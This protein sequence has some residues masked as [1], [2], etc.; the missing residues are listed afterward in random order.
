MIQPSALP[1]RRNTVLPAIVATTFATVI[2]LVKGITCNQAFAVTL[3]L[4]VLTVWQRNRM[5][6]LMAA[7]FFFLVKTLFVRIAFAIDFGLTGH[8]GFDLLGVTPAMLL[9]VMTVWQLYLDIAA[10]KGVFRDR[11]RI[12]LGIFSLI[13]ALSILNPANPLLNGLAGFERVILPNIMILFLSASIV[14]T[15]RDVERITKSLLVLGVASCLYAVGQY[16]LGAY[17]WEIDWLREVALKDGPQGLTIGLRGVELRLFSVFYGYMDFTFAN[18]LIFAMVLAS[19]HSWN[20][21]WRRLRLLYAVMW[22]AVLALSL[23]RMPLLMSLISAAVVLYLRSNRQRRKAIL[24]GV[25]CIAAFF[26]L[27][28][29]VAAPIFR[30]T[31]AAKLIRLAEMANPL[32]ASSLAVR[33]E[34]NWAPTLALVETHPLGVGVGYGSNTMAT[35]SVRESGLWMG[36]HNEL[37]QKALETGIPGALVFLLLLVSVFR[38]NLHGLKKNGRTA[39][40]AAGMIGTTVAFWVCSLVNLPFVGAA[41]LLY[42]AL[43]GALLAVIEQRRDAAPER[44]APP[45]V[46]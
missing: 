31:G 40:L 12:L 19:G 4:V 8:T 24:T 29:N 6:G 14:Y 22:L 17:P 44:Q 13:G 11:T 38:D 46:T 25:C 9:S 36:P 18:V 45:S 41:G 30:E 33:V 37:L 1:L 20:R 43:A 5:N 7:I 16:A 23:E 28:L 10:G 34:R 26:I 3:T 2:L 21:G 15:S 42:F 27:T 32:S 35:E 39:A